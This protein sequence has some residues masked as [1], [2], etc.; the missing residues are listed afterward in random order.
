MT[1]PRIETAAIAM[2]STIEFKAGASF[3]LPADAY[4]QYS[5]ALATAAVAAIDKAATI[6]NVGE[7]DALPED[8][9]I[10]AGNVAYQ[11]C[12]DHWDGAG[13]TWD[14]RQLVSDL[15]ARVI[16]FGSSHE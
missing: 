8:A 14:T 11:K 15:P 16:H 10:L 7:L 13:R 9:V 5:S 12:G 4:E 2:R 3:G 6:T 1:D